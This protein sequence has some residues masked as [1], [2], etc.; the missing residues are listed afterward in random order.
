[1][2]WWWSERRRQRREAETRRIEYYNEKYAEFFNLF[3]FYPEYIEEPH[4]HTQ[5]MLFFAR[6]AKKIRDEEASDESVHERRFTDANELIRYFHPD[7]AARI[8][9]W[10][11]MAEPEVVLKHCKHQHD[12]QIRAL[13]DVFINL[14]S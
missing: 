1:M 11:T 14:G 2:P 6:L 12:P 9:H 10:S 8:P 5:T 3:G 13:R 7:L 4:N